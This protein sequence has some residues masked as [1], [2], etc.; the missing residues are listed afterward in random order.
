M[1]VQSSSLRST[2]HPLGQSEVT[3]QSCRGAGGIPAHKT[4]LESSSAPAGKTQQR[5]PERFC[6]R[7]GGHSPPTWVPTPAAGD[8]RGWRGRG[9]LHREPVPHSRCLGQNCTPAGWCEGSSTCPWAGHRAGPRH[10]P[11]PGRGHKSRDAPNPQL[12]GGRKRAGKFKPPRI[13]L[14]TPE[15][16]Y[17]ATDSTARSPHTSE[18]IAHPQAGSAEDVSH[19]KFSVRSARTTPSYPENHFGVTWCKHQLPARAAE[20]NEALMAAISH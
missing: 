2:P 5:H 8:G 20:T 3:K 7:Q 11:T 12:P 18:G 13:K 15:S 10:I 17:Y 19:T 1:G 14:Q 4:G 16:L 6:S 9:K